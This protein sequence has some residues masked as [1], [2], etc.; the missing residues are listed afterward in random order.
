MG[1][2]ELLTSSDG[3]HGMVD[4]GGGA[5]PGYYILKVFVQMCRRR[6]KEIL[7]AHHFRPTDFKF[8]MRKSLCLTE[9]LARLSDILMPWMKV[10]DCSLE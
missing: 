3:G 7:F 10:M 2:G 9:K 6:A 5:N 8:S 4:I 1:Y